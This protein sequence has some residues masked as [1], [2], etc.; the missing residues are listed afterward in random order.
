MNKRKKICAFIGSRANYGSLASAM[1]AI[2]KHDELE[3]I[4]ICAASSLLEKDGKVIEK[5]RKDGFEVDGELYML[6]GGE[7]PQ[8]MAKSTGLGIIE[9]TNVLQKFKPDISL[10]VGDRFEV[11]AFVIA[12]AYMN[13]PIAHT[14]GGEVTGTIDESI[15]HAITKFSHVH[16]TASDDAYN[17]V[18]KLGEA[19]DSV[20][21]VGCP[22]ID[23]AKKVL[24]ENDQAYIANLNRVGVGAEIDY[25]NDFLIVSQHPVTS[26][27][28]SA[29]K[30]IFET[31][32]AIDKIDMQTIWLWPNADAGSSEISK[33]MRIWRESGKAKKVR[34][35]KNFETAT[36]MML[37]NKAKCLIGNSSSGIRECAFIGTP[38]VNIG[39]RQNNRERGVNVLDCSNNAEHIVAAIKTQINKSKFEQSGVYGLGDAGEKIAEVLAKLKTIKSQKTISY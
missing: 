32:K 37:L 36:Y 2:K 33:Q 31:L 30:Q 38:V 21:N 13:I 10:V 34:F 27:F 26:E 18:I 29:S 14:M 28:S 20:F 12:S 19:R 25:K 17:R 3:L 24:E 7:N 15:R 22:R 11:M 23:I 16:F 39:T 9:T 1:H 4:V 5:I 6:I 35:V 8:T